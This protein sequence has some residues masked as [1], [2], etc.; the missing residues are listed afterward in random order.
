MI[1]K[2]MENDM[3]FTNLYGQWLIFMTMGSRMD[4]PYVRTANKRLLYLLA[5]LLACLLVLAGRSS[6][7]YMIFE[8]DTFLRVDAIW[9]SGWAGM[10]I[11]NED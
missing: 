8:I 7:L 9:R 2:E 6:F 10:V 3:A 11:G 4:G 1:N 5:Y